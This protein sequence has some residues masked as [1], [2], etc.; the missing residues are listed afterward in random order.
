MKNRAGDPVWT[1]IQ[2]ARFHLSKSPE[3]G[4]EMKASL[5]E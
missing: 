4:G 3:N 1:D 2:P 5:T